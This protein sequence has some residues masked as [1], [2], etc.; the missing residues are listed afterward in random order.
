[1][2]LV[3][4]VIIIL[5]AVI[6]IAATSTLN[7]GRV[8]KGTISPLMQKILAD[9]GAREE[10]SRAMINKDPNQLIH[11]DGK[12]YCVRSNSIQQKKAADT[13]DW[14]IANARRIYL[15]NKDHYGLLSEM[16]QRELKDLEATMGQ[17]ID[18][19]AP[20]PCCCKK[21]KG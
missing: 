1:M 16:E 7:D 19:M 11:V 8:G 12:T 21:K 2:G 6:F 4:C 18:V 17:Q 15:I 10:L 13:C 20:L 9:P 5:F 14:N 3:L